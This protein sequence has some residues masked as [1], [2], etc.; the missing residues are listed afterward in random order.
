VYRSIRGFLIL[1][2]NNA[3][4][5]SVHL[6][7]TAGTSFGAA[8]QGH[9]GERYRDNYA[10]EGISRPV[11][12]R[13][14]LAWSSAVVI[15]NEGMG[16]VSCV[17]GH[18]LP[19]KFLLLGAQVELTFVTWMRDPVERL[20]SHYRF[21]QQTYDKETSLPHHRQVVEQK[22]TL[23][24]FCFSDQFRNIY[25]QYL[26]GFPLENFSF[27]GISEHFA[28]DM[29]YFARRYLGA[30][31]SVPHLNMSR[32]SYPGDHL[33]AGF[34]KEVKDFHAA[35]MALYRRA[36]DMRLERCTHETACRPAA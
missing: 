21:W 33:D 13:C 34:L 18:F 31:L 20:L 10:D 7:K 4:L 29:H 25:T 28:D 23:E 14:R 15:A 11:Q 27:V 26:W 2:S 3:A 32:P 8:L 22:W 1:K 35:D 19:A 12:E 24:Q 36:L 5:I 6:P 9:F 16:G 30:D 17:H